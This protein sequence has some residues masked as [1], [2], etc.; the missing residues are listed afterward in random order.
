MDS[1]PYSQEEDEEEEEDSVGY[2]PHVELV[3]AN[4]CFAWR[5]AVGEKSGRISTRGKKAAAYGSFFLH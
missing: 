3:G 5:L 1:V 2:S 4:I